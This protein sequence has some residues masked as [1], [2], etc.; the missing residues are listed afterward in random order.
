MQRLSDFNFELPPGLVAQYPLHRRDK[1]RLLVLEKKSGRVEHRSFSDLPDYMEKRDLLVLNDSRVVPARIKARR[2]SGGKAEVFLLERKNGLVFRALLK[3][4]R[5]KAG[6]RLLLSDP[7]IVCTVTAKDEVA[8]SGCAEKD[9]YASGSVP[10][11]PYIKREPSEEDRLYYQTVFARENGS[12]AA[13]TAGLHFTPEL[14]NTINAAG[15]RTAY[16]TLHVGY[17][18]FKPVKCEDVSRH[19]MEEE[20]YRIGEDALLR[21]RE[22]AASDGK[23]FAVGTTSLR[24]L[25]TYASS[26][27]REGRTGLFIYPGYDFRLVNRLVTNFH[28][29]KTTLL[30][31][32]CAFAGTE[33]VLDA[34]RQAVEQK[35]RFYSYGDAMLII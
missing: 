7:N 17:G 28:L 20:R 16:V 34:Y 19:I 30:M 14:L 33:M 27:E 21:I 32:V 3:P 29:P 15:A 10:L 13:P 18:T 24:V 25:E 12:V 6:E 2:R 4:A 35:Y 11:P 5:L 22:A 9:I 31:L 8:F 26:G 23:I 1:A